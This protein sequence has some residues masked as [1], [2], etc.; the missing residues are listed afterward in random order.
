[1]RTQDELI[2][3][4]NLVFAYRER[5][6]HRWP[7]PPP[8]DAMRFAFTEIA[9]AV[10]A[11]LREEPRYNRN[12]AAKGSTVAEELCDCAFMLLTALG[13]TWQPDMD[14]VKLPPVPDGLEFVGEMVGTGMYLCTGHGLLW[15]RVAERSLQAIASYPGLDDYNSLYSGI[16][17]RLDRIMARISNESQQ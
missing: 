2:K 8:L 1:M 4:R 7:T 13:P 12:N 14:D 3:L 11:K 9:E 5:M 16:A 15:M 17:T 6:E 10:E